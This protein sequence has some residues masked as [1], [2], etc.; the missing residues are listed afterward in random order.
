MVLANTREI[1]AGGTA[2]R[3]LAFIFLYS[4]RNCWPGEVNGELLGLVFGWGGCFCGCCLPS[5]P[6][7]KGT[8]D[9]ASALWSSRTDRAWAF[10]FVGGFG[11]FLLPFMAV[12]GK[13]LSLVAVERGVTILIWTSLTYISNSFS[14]V[15]FVCVCLLVVVLFCGFFCLVVFIFQIKTQLCIAT[16]AE[17]SCNSLVAGSFPSSG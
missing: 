7:L 6:R 8:P 1:K 16:F 9:T 14:V 4:Q 15:F 5:G 11:D 12:G 2:P 17:G 10:T 3:C 13:F